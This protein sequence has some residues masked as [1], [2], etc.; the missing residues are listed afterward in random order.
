MSCYLHHVP[1]RLR[2]KTPSVK[3]CPA[4]A[5]EIEGKLGT[6]RGVTMVSANII[7]G[8]ILITYDSA[9]VNRDDILNVLSREGYFDYTKA[10]T[11]DHV[12]EKKLEKTGQAL[13]K[14][15]LGMA[16]GKMFE[17]T[18]LALLTAII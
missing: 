13:G 15:I 12:F 1:G 3:G 9:S 4:R 5:R 8:S 18:P 11:Q 6:I 16:I 2:I 17:G 10:A 14:A 7:T